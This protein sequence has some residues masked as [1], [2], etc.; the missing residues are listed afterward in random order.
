VWKDHLS[1][2]HVTGG[3]YTEFFLRLHSKNIWGYYNLLSLGG[4]P[5]TL[6]LGFIRCKKE[7]LLEAKANSNGK[8]QNDRCIQRAVMVDIR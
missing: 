2:V 7:Y 3:Y 1:V 4:K 6:G 5:K 8:T